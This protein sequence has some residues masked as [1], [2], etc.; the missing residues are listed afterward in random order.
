MKI[1][2]EGRRYIKTAVVEGRNAQPVFKDV[3]HVLYEVG[4][5]AHISLYG[6]PYRFLRGLLSLLVGYISHLLHT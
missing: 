2:V 3:A 6:Q 5:V 1:E 4:R